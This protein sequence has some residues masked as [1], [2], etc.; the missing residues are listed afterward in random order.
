MKGLRSMKRVRLDSLLLMM[1]FAVT[2][3]AL[4]WTAV[5]CFRGIR[6]AY[7]SASKCLA[8]ARFT[9]NK[10]KSAEGRISVYSNHDGSLDRIVIGRNDDYETVISVSGGSL[11]EALCPEGS[12]ISYGE[13]VFSAEKLALSEA[14]GTVRIS[15]FSESGQSAVIYAEPSSETVFCSSKGG[16]GA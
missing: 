8:A 7:D 11:W 4:M 6:N 3:F 1:I 9:A 16:G 10:L 14:E 5:S 12:D 13:R 15:V 2:S